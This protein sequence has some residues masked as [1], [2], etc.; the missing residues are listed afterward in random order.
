M[1]QMTSYSHHNLI[2]MKETYPVILVKIRHDDVILRHV[3]SF[4]QFLLKK[5]W[6]QQK[7]GTMG[8]SVLIF[9]MR[10][11]N[12]VPTRGQ[13]LPYDKRL[14]SYRIFSFCR[15]FDDV[16][17]KNADV[18]KKSAETKFFWK[19]NVVATYGVSYRF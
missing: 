6:R 12:T 15:I 11:N 5:C 2:L 7:L 19:F 13:P 14:I 9:R 17:T 10:P 4:L 3:T 8:R 18:S 1:M 16:I